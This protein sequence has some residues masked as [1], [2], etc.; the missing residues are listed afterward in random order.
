MTSRFVARTPLN[1]EASGRTNVFLDKVVAR[2][3]PD[4]PLRASLSLTCITGD[5]LNP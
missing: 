2:G 3:I 5:T 4:V 1:V